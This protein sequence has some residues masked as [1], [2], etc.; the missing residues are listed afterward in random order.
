L[1]REE[2]HFYER[3]LVEEQK[4]TFDLRAREN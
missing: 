4:R 3:Q 2:E 1:E